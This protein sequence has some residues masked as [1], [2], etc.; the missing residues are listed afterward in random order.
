MPAAVPHPGRSRGCCDPSGT[1]W[2]FRASRCPNLPPLFS[3]PTSSSLLPPVPDP[4]FECRNASGRRPGF[5]AVLISPPEEGGVGG[6]AIHLHFE[7]AEKK[8]FASRSRDNAAP[9][10]VC[11]S[12]L[13]LPKDR[14]TPREDSSVW[15]GNGVLGLARSPGRGRGRDLGARG[16]DRAGDPGGSCAERAQWAVRGALRTAATSA[17]P[18]CTVS[19]KLQQLAGHRNLITRPCPFPLSSPPPPRVRGTSRGKV[20][21]RL[22]RKLR[23]SGASLPAPRPSCPSEPPR[24]GRDFLL[25]IT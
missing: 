18:R 13:G 12:P 7:G 25:T 15:P 24:G 10:P 17:C 5:R 3:S 2:G 9:C 19:V 11:G 22:A 23:G 1:S 6:T 14:A 8:L 20:A 21:L 4:I 16:V